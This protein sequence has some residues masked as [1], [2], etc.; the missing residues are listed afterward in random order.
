M[1]TQHRSEIVCDQHEQTDVRPIRGIL[2]VVDPTATSHP[3]IDKAARIATRS[4]ARIE[5][6]LCDDDLGPAESRVGG[7]D[8][9][10]YRGLRRQRFVEELERLAQPLR[11]AGLAVTTCCEW[12]AP[13]EQG[14]GYRALRVNPDLVIK[15][16]HRHAALP[17]SATSHTDW[18][19]I[20]HLAA[21]LLLVRPKP[22]RGQPR[23]AVCVDPC[24]PADR[25]ESLDSVM[26]ATSGALAGLLDARVEIV[27][28]L[29]SPPHLPDE[30]V[31]AH[32]KA[33]AHASART[34]VARVLA[35]A[36]ATS[37]PT[38]FVE[39]NVVQRTLE[40]A[41]RHEPDLL[42]FGAASRQ[43][44]PHSAAGG[45]AA[46][47]LEEVACDVLV[48]KPPGFLSPLL[49]TED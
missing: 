7:S 5:L 25:P 26:V 32:R 37:L 3:S 16:T 44:W 24:H 29:E 40:F 49:V 27:H 48:M 47:I 21:P 39:G 28:V 15:D 33:G 14:I 35:L 4:G 8:P 20:R 2:V 46:R 38:H 45:T 1:H 10:Q 12:H 43:H 34:A 31:S 6:Y 9:L 36:A 18:L 42:V 13:F 22:W 30:P 19:L 17:R 11:A 23:I 41:A